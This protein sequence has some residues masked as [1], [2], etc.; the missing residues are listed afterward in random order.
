MKTPTPGGT[1][2]VLSEVDIDRIHSASLSLL[3][4]L[5]VFCESDIILDIFEQGGA[6]V[7][8]EN[9]IIRV[10]PDMVAGLAPF[11]PRIFYILWTRSS[12]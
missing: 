1:Y 12:I 5:G 4:E 9:R 7:D 3:S 2:N 8:R 6:S 11:R 10:F